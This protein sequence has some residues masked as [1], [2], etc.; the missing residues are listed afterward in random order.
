VSVAVPAREVEERLLAGERV[1]PGSFGDFVWV[2]DVPS[3]HVLG[4][5]L[6]GRVIR[7]LDWGLVRTDA[8]VEIRVELGTLRPSGYAAPTSRLGHTVFGVCAPGEWGCTAVSAAPLDP[9]T[10]YVNAVGPIFARALRVRAESFSPL[11]EA[12]F[13]ELPGSGSIALTTHGP[14]PTQPR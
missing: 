12:V 7:T 4:A 14:A 5:S 13:S 1:V 2:F 11:G 9:R 3:G 10:G 6:A 8:E